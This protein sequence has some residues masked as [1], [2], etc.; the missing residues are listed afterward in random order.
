MYGFLNEYGIHMVDYVNGTSYYI[1]PTHDMENDRYM[2][3]C[4]DS[5]HK[6]FEKKKLAKDQFD[7][8]Y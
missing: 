8:E 4:S 7:I 1:Q 2:L 6:A 3:V 5:T